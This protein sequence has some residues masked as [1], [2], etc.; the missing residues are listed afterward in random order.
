[1]LDALMTAALCSM[2]G[3]SASVRKAFLTGTLQNYA[4]RMRFAIDTVQFNF[5]IV[6][7]PWE[8]LAERP[9][10]CDS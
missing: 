9:Q 6:E 2:M 1:M 8:E 7:T 4:R 3:F 10:V 5:I